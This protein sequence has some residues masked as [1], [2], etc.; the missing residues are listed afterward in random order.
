MENELPIL[1]FDVASPD[2][3]VRA[4]RGEEIGTRVTGGETAMAPAPTP[5]KR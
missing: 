4:V 2:G 5:A 3:I 1:V